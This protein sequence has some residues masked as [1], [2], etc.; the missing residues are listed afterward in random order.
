MPEMAAML[1]SV[2]L[3]LSSDATKVRMT[4]PAIPAPCPAA[5]RFW[6]CALMAAA[7][8]RA[9]SQPDSRVIGREPVEDGKAIKFSL[10]QLNQRRGSAIHG[11]REREVSGGDRLATERIDPN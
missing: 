7:I 1:L 9:C 4:L 8:W 6:D 11:H 3:E 10:C 5:T 2:A